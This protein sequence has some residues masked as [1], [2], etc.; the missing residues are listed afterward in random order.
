MQILETWLM[1][2]QSVSMTLNMI[3]HSMASYTKLFYENVP[4][5]NANR[6][7]YYLF[8]LSHFLQS[9]SNIWAASMP[10]GYGVL[11]I[12]DGQSII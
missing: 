8:F 10:E 12:L 2:I 6:L 3:K 4:I 1:W 5:S 11:N 9:R 7:I